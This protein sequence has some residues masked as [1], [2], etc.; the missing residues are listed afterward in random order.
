MTDKVLEH[1]QTMKELQ[2]AID[3]LKSEQLANHNVLQR[4]DTRM[5]EEREEEKLHQDV[6]E[7]RIQELEENKAKEEK[8]FFA[9]LWIQLRWKSYR[10]RKAMKDA[11]KGKKGK[12]GSKTAKK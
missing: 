4:L 5:M 11:A 6:K 2:L 7:K 10:K 3:K 1:E 12:K 8:K 9:A